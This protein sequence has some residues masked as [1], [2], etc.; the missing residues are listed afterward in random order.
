MLNI[1]GEWGA[2]RVQNLD[3]G[4]YDFGTDTVAGDQSGRYGPD[5]PRPCDDFTIHDADPRRE[6]QWRLGA[7][8]FVLSGCPLPSRSTAAQ[9]A[10]AIN[11]KGRSANA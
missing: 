8:A 4:I 7:A 2:E 9:P 3:N 1:P 11:T 6:C 5:V 10:A